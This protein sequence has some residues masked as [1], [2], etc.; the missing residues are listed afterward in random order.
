MKC[1]VIVYNDDIT[2]LFTYNASWIR[3]NAINH[4]YIQSEPN[5][6]SNGWHFSVCRSMRAESDF[7]YTTILVM[8]TYLI[9][10]VWLGRPECRFHSERHWDR[11]HVDRDK[12]H[13]LIHSD[14][15]H[16]G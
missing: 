12:L 11:S 14:S 6:I 3:S 8:E 9:D 2:I 4:S 15:A 1:Y 5:E 10:S 13:D 16:V 7:K